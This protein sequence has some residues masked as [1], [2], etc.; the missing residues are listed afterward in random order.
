MRYRTSPANGPPHITT[1]KAQP[2]AR[3][4]A[5]SPSLP[6]RRDVVGDLFRTQRPVVDRGFVEAAFEAEGLVV[7]AAEEQL[8]AARRD[9][10]RGLAVDLPLA[11]EVDR[12]LLAVAH[13][14]DVVPL[15]QLQRRRARERL[16]LGV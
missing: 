7:A 15:S 14:G 3:F 2:I 12:D 8:A 6:R 13:Q 16:I 9:R 10:D 1:T 5:G 11:V 4:P